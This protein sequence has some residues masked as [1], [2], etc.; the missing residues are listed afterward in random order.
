[1]K[2]DLYSIVAGSTAC[3]A[4]C[5]YCI[6][7]MTPN[8]GVSLDEPEVNW[9]NL[10]IGAKLARD[11]GAYTAM[12]TGKGE[13]T[14]FPEQ[15]TKYID[16][17]SS[18]GFP[19]IELQTNGIALGEQKEKYRPLLKEWYDKGLTTVAISIA[20]YENMKNREVFLPHGEDY[21]DLERTVGMLH[22]IGYSVRLSCV[23]LNRYIDD[24]REL[25]SMID[26]SKKNKVEQLTL[27]PVN[28]PKKSVDEKA[29]YYF[30]CAKLKKKQ[31]KSIEDY[32]K[33]NGKPLLHLTHGGVVYD[34]DG[35]NVCLTNSL[36]IKPE[37]DEIRQLIFFPDGHLRYDWQY[38]GAVIL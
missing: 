26:F 24:S 28:K 20:H 7:K 31:L 18:A 32:L 34:V 23:M 8:Q 36:T 14:L 16:A 22:D 5:G 33:N 13:P 11:A 38:E 25:Q 12:I 27:R 30:E 21:P 9:R 29:E 10:K 3:N 19:L 2:I 37:T 1:M 15:L 17:L 4:K 35:Q 6:S